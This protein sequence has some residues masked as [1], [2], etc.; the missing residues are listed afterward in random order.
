[1]STFYAKVNHEMAES[2]AELRESRAELCK[3]HADLHNGLAQVSKILVE[4]QA[5]LATHQSHLQALCQQCGEV[6]IP[7]PKCHIP[8]MPTIRENTALTPLGSSFI[9][10]TST[11]LV[12]HISTLMLDSPTTHSVPSLPVSGHSGISRDCS[13]IQYK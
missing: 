4:L 9:S 2:H 1:M 3:H 10:N 13:L 8:V 11:S 5:S 7:V 12:S 6:T